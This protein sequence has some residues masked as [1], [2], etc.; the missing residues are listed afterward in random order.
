MRKRKIG[1]SMTDREKKQREVL[2]NL[3]ERAYSGGLREHRKDIDIDYALS[4]LAKL[5]AMP[6]EV[7]KILERIK[8]IIV[9]PPDRISDITI[10]DYEKIRQA[11]F[12]AIDGFQA[13]NPKE[14]VGVEEFAKSIID[15]LFDEEGCLGLY[16]SQVSPLAVWL[17]KSL[18]TKYSI[19]R[20]G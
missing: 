19:T 9:Q 5:D 14:E 12:K 10:E 13:V 7:P 11:I 17:A 4:E 20:K 8:D 6:K 16:K 18:L 15:R 1:G 3:W 2:E